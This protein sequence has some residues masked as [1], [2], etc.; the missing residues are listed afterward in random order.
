MPG[1]DAN[2]HKRAAGGYAARALAYRSRPLARAVAGTVGLRT[3]ATF[4]GFLV[5]LMLARILGAAGYGAYAYAMAWVEVL[6]ILAV[7]GFD[8]LLVREVAAGAERRSWGPAR[9]LVD[10]ANRAVFAFS[11][12]LAVVA[13][14]AAK[15][16]AGDGPDRMALAIAVAVLS[17]PPLALTRLRQSVLQGLH[18]VVL[19]QTAESVIRPVV[20]ALLLAATLALGRG[21]SSVV[22][23]LFANAVAVAVSLAAATIFLR[24]H[25]PEGLRA[26]LPEGR[27]G[28]WARSV[29]YLFVTGGLLVFNQRLGTILLGAIRGT[30]AVGAFAIALQISFFV[31]FGQLAVNVVIPPTLSRF[32]AAGDRA[33][34]QRVVV[35][36]A[37]FSFGLSLLFTLVLVVLG[38]WI[39]SVFGG[40]FVAG[41]PSLVILSMGLV[42]VSAVGPAVPLLLMTGHERDAAMGMGVSAVVH[43]VA[44]LLLI[45]PWG[46]PGAATASTL[47]LVVR[48]AWFVLAVRRRL[49]VDSSIWGGRWSGAPV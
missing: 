6:A 16:F 45:P 26:A 39:L 31:V 4:L 27:A 22:G 33:G 38:R 11:I 46:G 15:I 35:K 3:V 40:G 49:G 12:V 43:I 21:T 42:A 28:T 7:M 1:N 37:R 8:R 20:F 18:H 13:A 17:L 47:G 24:R 10:G 41:Y 29:F 48:T 34:T 32:H 9:G 36:A 25:E 19:G 5:S 44:A 30:E 14:G 2:R 23:A